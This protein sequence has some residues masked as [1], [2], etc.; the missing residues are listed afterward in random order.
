MSQ[1][2]QMMKPIILRSFCALCRYQSTFYQL[3]VAYGFWVVT[4]VSAMAQREVQYAQ[5]LVNPLAI[6][7]AA[8]GARENFHFNAV[9]RRQFVLGLQGLPI[10]QSFAMDGTVGRNK[11]VGLGLQGINDRVSLN[12]AAF[13]TVSYIHRISETQKIAIGTLVGVNV[14][15][16]RSLVG[17]GSGVNQA[18]LSAGVGIYYDDEL[19][20]GGISMPE[21]LNQDYAYSSSSA[22]LNYRRP[23]FVQAGIKMG[24]TDD[25]RLTPSILLTKPQNGKLRA[26]LNALA[27]L[28]NKFGAGASIRFGTTTYWQALLSYDASKNIRLGYTYSSRRVEDFWGSANPLPGSGKGIHEI[29]VTLQPNPQ[30]Q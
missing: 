24:T 16:S 12:T 6:N 28:K 29:V 8:T 4:S 25:F 19:I 1:K 9:L 3:L 23:I 27:T 30:A 22:L 5:Y 21:I 14:L 20:F 7:P 18:V 10:T 11:N 13:A 17:L 26:D 15:P 2:Q